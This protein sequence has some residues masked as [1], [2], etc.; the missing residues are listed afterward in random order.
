ML[1]FECCASHSS[2][3]LLYST[4]THTH[5]PVATILYFML[6]VTSCEHRLLNRID[7]IGCLQ[8]RDATASCRPIRR[9]Q[10][11]P[12]NAGPFVMVHIPVFKTQRVLSSHHTTPHHT[13]SNTNKRVHCIRIVSPTENRCLL[14]ALKQSFFFSSSTC[15]L[16]LLFF[17]CAVCLFEYSTLTVTLYCIVWVL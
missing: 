4:H 10:P 15:S 3:S 13:N 7:R 8:R 17:A 6:S 9:P 1:Y 11:Q 14:C 16:V 2:S 12:K 5:V